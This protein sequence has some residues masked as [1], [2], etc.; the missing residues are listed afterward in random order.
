VFLYLWRQKCGETAK[1]QVE[2]NEA[3]VSILHCNYTTLQLYYTVYTVYIQCIY[4]VYALYI[5]CIYSVYT[6]YMIYCIH[7]VYNTLYIIYCI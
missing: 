1:S 6:V 3:K 2:I 4:T 5:H 7:T